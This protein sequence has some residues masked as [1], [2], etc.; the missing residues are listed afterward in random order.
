MTRKVLESLRD[1]GYEPATMLDVGA[2]VGGF[3]ESFLQV[4]PDCVPT[5][6]EPN[7]YCEADLAKL[8]FERHMVAASDEA[9]V[10][11]LFLSKDWLQSTG[12]SLY[13]EDTHYFSDEKVLKHATPGDFNLA[14]VAEVEAVRSSHSL[15]VRR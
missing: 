5:L 15:D 12:V 14:T 7:P 8:G 3:T 6:V 11:E 13:R 9:G 1:Q 4:F 10:A 2:N